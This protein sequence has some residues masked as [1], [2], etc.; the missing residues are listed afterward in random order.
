MFTTSNST[1]KKEPN[2]KD[3]YQIQNN[4]CSVVDD[5][6]AAS[7][8]LSILPVKFCERYGLDYSGIIKASPA[9]D[10][11]EQQHF[12]ISRESNLLLQIF[13]SNEN[14]ETIIMLR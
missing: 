2:R 1:S 5:N 12:S 6:G 7:H 4:V 13:Y 14:L 9:G 10:N 3:F 8:G 11:P